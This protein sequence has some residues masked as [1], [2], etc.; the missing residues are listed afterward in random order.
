MARSYRIQFLNDIERV[1]D[2]KIRFCFVYDYKRTSNCVRKLT[3]YRRH[4]D[5]YEFC[6]LTKYNTN[7]RRA[8]RKRIQTVNTSILINSIHVDL[9]KIRERRQ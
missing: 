7:V 4:F 3:R 5:F 6:R 1:R 8:D 2:D 9:E